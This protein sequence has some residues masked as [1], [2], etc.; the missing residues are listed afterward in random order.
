MA[1]SMGR[2]GDTND[3]CIRDNLS[4]RVVHVKSSRDF[5]ADNEVQIKGRENFDT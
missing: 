1:F 2:Q 5:Q 3:Y 4:H